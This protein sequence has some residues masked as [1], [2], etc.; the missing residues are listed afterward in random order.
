LDERAT[1]HDLVTRESF[2][3]H[4][5]SASTTDAACLAFSLD[6]TTLAVGQRDGQI[7]LWDAA[8]RRLQKTMAAHT[9]F[10]AAIAFGPDGTTLA[11]AAGGEI[12]PIKLKIPGVLALAF[13]PDDATL[14][15][16]G[17][18]GTVDCG[19]FPLSAPSDA[20]RQQQLFTGSAVVCR[21]RPDDESHA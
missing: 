19:D 9:D 3:L 17:L 16:G 18:D 7:T 11:S 13:A 5:E 10:V 6:G 21:S 2:P 4:D 20:F 8:T 15:T 14:A 12:R 1:L